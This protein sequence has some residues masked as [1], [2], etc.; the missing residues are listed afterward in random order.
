MERDIRE[1][2][3]S[4]AALPQHPPNVGR[5]I[6]R[7]RMLR[8]RR[9]GLVFSAVAMLLWSIGLLTSP[10][11]PWLLESVHDP[12][13]ASEG[14][15][16]MPTANQMVGVTPLRGA[17]V[18]LA[19]G[20][21]STWVAGSDGAGKFIV[22]RIDHLT[23]A[24]VAE[25]PLSGAPVA[26]GFH[27]SYLWALSSRVGE[28]GGMIERIDP[29]TNSVVEPSLS[30]SAT[31]TDLSFTDVAWVTVDD[32]SLLKVAADGRRILDRQQHGADGVAAAAD[33]IWL[34][35]RDGQVRSINSGTRSES[36]KIPANVIDVVGA[37]P[38]LY[39]TQHTADGTQQLTILRF[40]SGEPTSSSVR[41]PLG[42][43][44]LAVGAGGIWLLLSG[45]DEAVT[46]EAV[47]IDP[48]SEEITQRVVVGS[49]PMDVAADEDELWV[50]NFND[51]TVMRIFVSNN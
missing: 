40:G 5:A 7:G 12:E 24:V 32:G 9:R 28:G 1:L 22:S 36:V 41:L 16:K 30:L 10:V 8:W 51:E 37:A 6:S 2:L 38:A 20:A 23:N 26:V 49:G 47:R 11:T 18:R 35:T 27:D 42:P 15:T 44:K 17:P 29:A 31:P 14:G 50:A 19:L 25:I 13:S 39:V 43:G 4:S 33:A 48:A 34:F 21:G 45:N 3:R 46:G